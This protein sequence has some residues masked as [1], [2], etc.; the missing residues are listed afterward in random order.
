M[1]KVSVAKRTLTRPRENRIS[2]TSAHHI[3]TMPRLAARRLTF[4]E[5]KETTMM[6]TDAST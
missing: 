4:D 2:T 1:A 5:W 6:H 3:K